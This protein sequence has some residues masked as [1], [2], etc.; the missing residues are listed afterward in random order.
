VAFKP[1]E[2]T[3]EQAALLGTP[4]TTANIILK[5]AQ[6]TPG[7]TVL[8]LGSTGSVGTWVMQLSQAQGCKTI[9][10]G[11]YGTDVD[12]TQDPTLSK[13]K[14][15]TSGKGPDIAVDTVGEFSLTNAAF[16]VLGKNGR[17]CT[18]TAPRSGST[19]LPI[20]ILSL[21]RRQISIIGCNSIGYT[22]VEM[23]KMFSDDL[24]PLIEQGKV[25][26]PGLGNTVR[27]PIDEA[28]DVYNGKVKKAVIV[29]DE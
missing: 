9:G 15:M 29:F 10:V 17:L 5:R 20:D 1:K 4:F 12:S 16:N 13:V 21:Y 18:I 14:D 11:R 8:V 25:K 28:L 27:L 24:V 23:A 26:V 7:E 3:F 19:E 6:C 2:I 22:Q